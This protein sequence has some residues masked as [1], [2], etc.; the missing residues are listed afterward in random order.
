MTRRP[1]RYAPGLRVRWRSAT[2]AAGLTLALLAATGCASAIAGGSASS[3]PTGPGSNA[4]ISTSPLTPT[5]PAASRVPA[6]APASS[7]VSVVGPALP[8][9]DIRD[10]QNLAPALKQADLVVQVTAGPAGQSQAL[11]TASDGSVLSPF[12]EYDFDSATALLDPGQVVAPFALYDGVLEL[13]AG[14]SYILML[15]KDPGDQSRSGRPAYAISLGQ[16]GV[17]EVAN[18]GVSQICPHYGPYAAITRAPGS[19]MPVT[20]FINIL[21]QAQ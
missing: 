4:L 1:Y 2:V 14:Q 12:W 10:P 19:G 5:S 16:Q 17:F 7:L 15:V 21:R 20:Q 6:T 18:D 13:A 11:R 8:P 9:C 3:A